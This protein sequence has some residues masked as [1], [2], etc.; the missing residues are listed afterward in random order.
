MA[1]ICLDVP[2]EILAPVVI[3]GLPLGGLGMV[4]PPLVGLLAE[5]PEI[6]ALDRRDDPGVHGEASSV[7]TLLNL[8]MDVIGQLQPNTFRHGA[9]L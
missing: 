6:L 8:R 2:S 4:R 3:G 7:G 9:I 1:T 5:L